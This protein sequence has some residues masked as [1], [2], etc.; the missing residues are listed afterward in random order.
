MLMGVLAAVAAPRFFGVNSFEERGFADATLAALRFAQ[1]V[2]VTSG[3]DTAVDFS[4]TGYQVLQRAGCTVGAFQLLPNPAGGGYDQQ[5]PGAVNLTATDLYFDKSGRPRAL[6]SG[7]P[8]TTSVNIGVG[9]RTLAVE[10]ETGY[11]HA[12]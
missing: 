8:F 6:S 1:K 4:A 3:C 11:A 10:P 9:G 2:A 7:N 5:A 12:I